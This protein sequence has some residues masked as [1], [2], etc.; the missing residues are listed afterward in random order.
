M[1]PTRKNQSS[2][3]PKDALERD[4]QRQ[5][6]NARTVSR[7]NCP[8][9]GVIY[10][11]IGVVIRPKRLSGLQRTLETRRSVALQRPQPTTLRI[12][13]LVIVEHRH[14][15]ASQVA[16]ISTGFAQE[17]VA[18]RGF[19]LQRSVKDLLKPLSISRSHGAADPFFSN[20]GQ[21]TISVRGCGTASELVSIRNRRPSRLAS[22]G[23]PPMP[24]PRPDRGKRKSS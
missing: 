8:E 24:T 19:L 2:T 15:L 13:L 22:Y 18:F 16:V 23:L 5:L 9:A 11:V 4:F 1:P 3:P 6:Q 12:T 10:A 17:G 14:D 7:C 21:L 20:A